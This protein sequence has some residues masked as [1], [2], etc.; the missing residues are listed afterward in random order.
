M[1]G[2][3]PWEVQETWGEGGGVDQGFDDSFVWN[4]PHMDDVII[5][6]HP[7][8]ASKAPWDHMP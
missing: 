7:G 6:L 2:R 5:A 1:D 4:E 3:G 8:L